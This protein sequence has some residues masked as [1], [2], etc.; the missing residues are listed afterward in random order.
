MPG[1][2][3]RGGDHCPVLLLC[4]ASHSLLSFALLIF[5]LPCFVWLGIALLSFAQ[6]CRGGAWGNP[7]SWVPLPGSSRLQDK[8]RSLL[9]NKVVVSRRCA[10]VPAG[11][12]VGVPAG[13]PAG[14]LVGVLPLFRCSGWCSG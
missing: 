11:V 9:M 5:A 8:V 7:K 13:V 10:G 1:G 2:A 12:P 6:L 4:F 14:V 3:S